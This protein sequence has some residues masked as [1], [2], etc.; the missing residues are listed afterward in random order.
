MSRAIAIFGTESTGKT[1]LARALAD[2]F[3]CPWAPEYVREFWDR[4]DGEIRANDLSTIAAG[5]LQNMAAAAEKAREL[6]IYDTELLTNTLWADLLFPAACPAWVR[7]T[8]DSQARD[9]TLYLLCDT[10]IAFAE[11]PQRCFPDAAD[12]EACRLRWREALNQR[13]LLYVT[14]TGNLATR[15]AQATTAITEA[16]GIWPG[17]RFRN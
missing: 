2:I 17:N 4:H 7:D 3:E 8:A 14:L 13:G 1:T 9:M 5:Q 15:L 10:D 16:T 12:R 6:V 11:D